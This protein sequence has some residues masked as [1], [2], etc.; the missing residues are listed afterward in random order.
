MAIGIIGNDKENKLI[1][2]KSTNKYFD[3]TANIDI[4]DS[5]DSHALI[6]KNIKGKST[7]LDIGCSQGLIGKYLKEELDCK[8]YG[9]E[10]D[11]KAA[12]YARKTNCY[13]EVFSFNISIE[14][15]K[16]YID[17][18]KRK[19]KYDYI[20][21]ADV[22]EHLIYPADVLINFSKLLNRNGYIIVS[23]PNIAHYDIINGLLNETF[24]YSDMGLLDCTHI[25]FFTKY[26][27]AQYINSINK[28]T[29][30]KFDLKL[31]DKTIIKP[32]FYGKY[33]N[34]D[35]IIND[36]N[37]MVVLQNIFELSLDDKASNLKNILGEVP[38][39]L[40]EEIDNKIE[41]YESNIKI[42]ENENEQLKSDVKRTHNEL[43]EL[44]KYKL[45]YEQML[46]RK[47]WKYSKLMRNL[48]LK[49]KDSKLKKLPSNS[50]TSILFF[51]HSWVNIKN[52]KSSFIGGTTINIL[53]ILDVL[54]HRYNCYV[55]TV[56][57]NRYVLVKV[58]ID[59][60]EIYD[61]GLVVNVREFDAYDYSFYEKIN[62]II[63][64]L[65]IDIIHINHIINF[66]CDLSI[67]SKK[68]KTI[69]TLHDYSVVC[70]RY[71]LINS[72]DVVCDGPEL[73]KCSNCKYVS[74]FNL[75][76]RNEAIRNLLNNASS[77]VFPDNSLLNYIKKYYDIK[78]YKVIPH[79]I[80][81]KKFSEFEYCDHVVNKKHINVAFV[82]NID[83]HKGGELVYNLII[84]NKDE[85]L[86]YH[87]Y[88]VTNNELFRS[89]LQN[90]YYHGIY[91]KNELPKKLNE[92]HIDLVLFLNNC[93]E[94]F[95]YTLSEVMYAQIPS[96]SF[97]IGAIGNRIR[98]YNVGW[99]IDYT[100]NP[101]DIKKMYEII[102]KTKEY[103]EKIKNLKR[104]KTIT[105]FDMTKELEMLYDVD[106]RPKNSYHTYKYLNNYIVNY[107]IKEEDLL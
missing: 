88:G 68:I 44:Y 74:T 29:N 42:L 30:V 79:G 25:R 2:Y 90:Y 96:M 69:I 106:N 38:V 1:N 95:S 100:R 103:N 56:L 65:Q 59:K 77:V 16:K 45:L 24:N 5:N 32:S 92:D 78:N 39:N 3:N 40:T 49:L 58:E 4:S 52:A 20:I 22:L 6:C 85:H 91:Q 14:N 46:N 76:V 50:K 72:K 48:S 83:G 54:K 13:E 18:F 84:N 53:D 73:T 15:E 43:S 98:K 36:N 80:N 107:T 33:P 93:I 31:L 94:S 75:E 9:I 10:I 101:E 37:D 66:P 61:L 17:F 28:T 70:P 60:Q 62:E 64:N 81:L 12:E 105:N 102:F 21:F 97:D 87:F 35:K 82:G 7:V 19:Q 34:V 51:V 47:S 89:N 71:F 63:N 8:V 99:V 67:I 11:E 26:S 55:I 41:N 104:I 86:F 27:F 23:L 57:N